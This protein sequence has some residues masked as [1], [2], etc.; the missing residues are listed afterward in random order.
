MNT[1]QH[2][3][4]VRREQILN[5]S[6]DMI[7]RRGFES[8]KIRDIADTLNISVGLFF[9]YFES[10]EAV[11]E[12]LVRFGLSGPGSLLELN[13]EGI[14]P[15]ELFEKMTATIFESLQT[16]SIASKIFLLMS[17]TVNSDAVPDSVKKLVHDFDA[18]SPLIPT[19][20]KGQECGEIKL[21]DPTA[22]AVAYWGAV[23]GIAES[24]AIHPEIP[25]PE[26]GWI[27]DI[28]R[29]HPF[30]AVVSK[31]FGGS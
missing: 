17:Q 13:V 3:R 25:L 14:G 5:C 28:L 19:I 16:N 20:R 2:Q 18:V 4:Q 1:R 31:E 11:Y 30:Q 8:M 27:V 12:E 6:L 7:I 9:N 26:S 15:I 21:G 22:L 10:K 24:F 23:Q 29:A